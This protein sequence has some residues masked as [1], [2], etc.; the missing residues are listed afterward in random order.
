MD[1]IKYVEDTVFSAVG[2][3]DYDREK[4]TNGIKAY[5]EDNGFLNLNGAFNDDIIKKLISNNLASH[6][7]GQTTESVLFFSNYRLIERIRILNNKTLILAKEM[8]DKKVLP[9]DAEKDRVR[10]SRNNKYS[11]INGF[12]GNQKKIENESV[13]SRTVGNNELSGIQAL[14][15]EFESLLAEVYAAEGLKDM[16]KVQLNEIILNLDSVKNGSGKFSRRLRDCKVS[17]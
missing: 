12:G 17:G 15:A 16:L 3:A 8:T 11:T 13:G 6:L 14:E 1:I 9:F 10:N 5:V 7:S 4:I 2:D